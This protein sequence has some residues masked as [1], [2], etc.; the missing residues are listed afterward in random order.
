MQEFNSEFIEMFLGVVRKYMQVRGQMSQKDLAEAAK[1]GVSTMSRFL[2]QKTNDLNGQLIAR[3]VATL[4]IPLHEIIDFVHESYTDGFIRLVKFYKEEIDREASKQKMNTGY[5]GGVPGETQ[6]ANFKEQE[7]KPSGDSFIDDLQGL[8]TAA[9]SAE[10][11]VSASAGGPKRTLR[12]EADQNAKNS[13]PSIREKLQSLS[14]RQRA[15]LTDFLNLDMEGRDLMVDLGNNL[16]RYFKQK[17]MN[18]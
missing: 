18:I 10:A 6:D 16:F 11:K 2:N 12:F 13:E 4:S 3:I 14:P 15:Y 5:P 1:V 8:G 7:A 17:G 9:R